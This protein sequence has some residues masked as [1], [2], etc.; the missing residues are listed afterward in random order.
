MSKGKYKPRRAITPHPK[1]QPKA[2]E[3]PTDPETQKIQWSFNRF[4]NFHWHDNKYKDPPLN[5]IACQLK[6]FESMTW[7][8]LRYPRSDLNHPV[9]LERIIVEASKRLVDSHRDD[10]DELWRLRLGGTERLWGLRI[11]RVFCVLW[12]DPLHK[13]YRCPKKHT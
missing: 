13:I 9:D 1:L 4:D 7:R 11:G 10:Y 12:W 6:S 5:E 3:A 2:P 8:Q